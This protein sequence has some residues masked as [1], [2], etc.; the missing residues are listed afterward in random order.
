[1]RLYGALNVL[2]VS[3]LPGQMSAR[4]ADGVYEVC[5]LAACSAGRV[6][7]D[8]VIRRHRIPDEL[9]TKHDARPFRRTGWCRRAARGS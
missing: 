1:M 4:L 2:P 5:S 7:M 3:C 9:Q 8:Q 6:V